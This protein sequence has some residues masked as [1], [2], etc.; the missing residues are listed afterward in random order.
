MFKYRLYDVGIEDK[1]KIKGILS[2]EK[3]LRRTRIEKYNP[4]LSFA[5]SGLSVGTF[6]LKFSTVDKQKGPLS[7]VLRNPLF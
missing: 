5:E 1:V 4:K 7:T 6:F 2:I 3:I